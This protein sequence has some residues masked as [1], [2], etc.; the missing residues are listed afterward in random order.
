[1]TAALVTGAAFSGSASAVHLAEDGIGQVLLGPI[2]LGL[3]NSYT[4]HVA[5]VNTRDDVA[6]KAKVVLRSQYTSAEVLDFICYLT[7]SDVCRFDIIN[8]NGQATF[9]SDDDSVR[10][11]DPLTGSEGT[12]FASINPIQ[13]QLFDQNLGAGDNNEIGHIEVIG[14]Y[15]V[16]GVINT[17]SGNVTIAKGMSKFALAAVFDVA[18]TDLDARNGAETVA[19]TR[20]ANGNLSPTPAG[21]IRSADPTWVQLTGQLTLRAPNGDRMGYRFPA[22]AGEVEDNVPPAGEIVYASTLANVPF[23]G[24]V[25]SNPLYDVQ[26]GAG[27]AESAVGFNFGGAAYG[28]RTATYDNIME[29]EYAMSTTRIQGT[30]EDD[31]FTSP[32]A[33]VNRTQLVITF[34]TKYRHL[35]DVC[36]TGVTVSSS[37]PWYPPFEAAGPITYTLT[38]YDNQEHSVAISGSIFSGGSAPKSKQLPFEVNYFIPDWNATVRD[39]NGNIRTGSYNYESGWFDMLISPRV[40]CPYPGAPIL[41]FAHK[42][43]INSTGIVNSWLVPNAHKPEWENS[44]FPAYGTANQ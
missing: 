14:A 22:L 25:I 9:Y 6:V 28:V 35:R 16:N 32:V 38:Q 20:D 3:A 24:R 33:G 44:R 42:Y 29:L 19:L 39:A 36:G 40:G 26:G 17:P 2:Y 41:S 10:G 30:Y 23:D 11:N 5:I 8:V 7:P 27:A 37:A 34:P 31:G 21:R 12:S 1:M 13:A 4:T 43:Q 15:A 18:R